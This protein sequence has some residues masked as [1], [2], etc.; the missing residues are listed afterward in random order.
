MA[1]QPQITAPTNSQTICWYFAAR[2]LFTPNCYKKERMLHSSWFF[3][4]SSMLP[5]WTGVSKSLS[6]HNNK[7]SISKQI[8]NKNNNN[9]KE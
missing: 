9:E 1:I 7:T 3:V 5:L 6:L 8:F 2:P 4:V